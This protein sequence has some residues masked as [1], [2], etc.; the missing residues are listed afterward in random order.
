[1]I[2]WKI[3]SNSLLT[4]AR[5][6]MVFALDNALCPLCNMDEENSLH[7]LWSCEFTRA[8]WFGCMWQV[9]TNALTAASWEDWLVWFSDEDKRPNRMHLHLF[10]GGTATVFEEIWRV[11]NKL[12]HDNT[13][14]PLPVLIH[15]INQRLMELTSVH[16]GYCSVQMTWLPPP[17]GWIMCNTDISLGNSES[18][19][20]AIFRN[21]K[22][23]TLKIYT[24]HSY[25]MDS[26][27]GEVYALVK[28]AEMAS[29]LGFNKVIFQS[30]SINAINAIQCNQ[31]SLRT[32][33]HNIQSLLL[34]FDS[35]CLLSTCGR[36]IGSEET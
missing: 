17:P 30:D 13:H 33:H 6:S 7:L 23:D 19:G 3:L 14:E 1:M 36:L 8:I 26:L 20:A 29:E 35:A 28:G 31:S 5:L 12:T 10:L 27:A 11:R 21:D 18:A 16:D 32:N 2:W 9:R 34:K 25:Y 15:R 4:K 22:G 24:F